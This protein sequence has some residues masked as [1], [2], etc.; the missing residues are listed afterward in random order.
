MSFTQYRCKHTDIN[1][2]FLRNKRFRKFSME[3]KKC[4]NIIFQHPVA[5]ISN[6]FTSVYNANTMFYFKCHLQ[7][8]LNFVNKS[9]KSHFLFICCNMFRPRRAI[10]RQAVCSAV[11][12]C[13]YV[14]KFQLWAA[15]GQ[16]NRQCSR[17]LPCITP[18]RH[19][20]YLSKIKMFHT[21]VVREN[22]HVRDT[23]FSP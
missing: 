17:R 11:S 15:L 18:A 8:H 2:H 21:K 1:N 6:S 16:V 12:A 20:G 9:L 22:L 23:F 7:S 14:D 13:P 5:F 3:H 19:A 10:I 4:Y